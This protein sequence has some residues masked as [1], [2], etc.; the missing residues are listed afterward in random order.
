M[1]DYVLSQLKIS[2]ERQFGRTPITKSDMELLSSDIYHKTKH[3]VSYNTLRRFYG[4]V[5]STKTSSSVLDFFAQ[6]CGF[7]SFHEFEVS[8]LPDLNFKIWN[9]LSESDELDDYLLAEIKKKALKQDPVALSNLFYLF[10]KII[11]IRPVEEWSLFYYQLGLN[12][13]VT[14]EN[15]VLLLIANMVGEKLRQTR[16]SELELHYLMN[17]QILRES[18]VYNFV[19]YKTLFENGFYAQLIDQFS[20]IKSEE[21]VFK[22]SLIALKH[23]MREE[24]EDALLNLDIVSEIQQSE[25]YFPIINGRIVMANVLKEVIVDQ[26]ISASTMEMIDANIRKQDRKNVILYSMEILPILAQYGPLNPELEAILS[27]VDQAVVVTSTWNLKLEITMYYLSRYIYHF[28]MKDSSKMALYLNLVAADN[29]LLFY[30]EYV[31]QL[32]NRY[33]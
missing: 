18:L 3:L 30:R 12:P 15:N 7:G 23:F 27:Y 28:R 4:T 26:T 21:V 17:N 32:I 16:F 22:H 13:K 8:N 5:K 33:R 29:T 11:S 6:Y 10:Q 20:P 14:E 25:A 2:V 24:Y 9:K 31:N 1:D 19:D